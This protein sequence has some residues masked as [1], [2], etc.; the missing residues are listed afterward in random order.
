MKAV[1]ALALVGVHVDE[2]ILKKNEYLAAEN[3]ILHI[4]PT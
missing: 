4:L 3:Q 2:E 1:E